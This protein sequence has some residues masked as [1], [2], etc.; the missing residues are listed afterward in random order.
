LLTSA[1]RP[2]CWSVF[3]SER[4]PAG[5]PLMPRRPAGFPG[6]ACVHRRRPAIAEATSG[7]TRRPRP[8]PPGHVNGLW[9]RYGP[10]HLLR[11]VRLSLEP[12]TR[13]RA[14]SPRPLLFRAGRE[15]VTKRASAV[16]STLEARCVPRP[17]HGLPALLSKS[18]HTSGAATPS[19]EPRERLAPVR[20]DQHLAMAAA[21]SFG[22]GDRRSHR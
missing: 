17:S 16:S 11:L 4:R 22:G 20:D 19:L 9:L 5:V 3:F 6:G 14:S 15:Q 7:R 10:R 21:T 18:G 1:I 13:S 8:S 2:T 12:A